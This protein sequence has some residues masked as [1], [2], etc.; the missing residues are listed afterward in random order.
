MRLLSPHLD[1]PPSRGEETKEKLTL[2]SRRRSREK[3]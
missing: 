2:P 1:P 3:R